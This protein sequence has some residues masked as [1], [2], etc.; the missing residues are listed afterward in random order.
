MNEEVEGR[1]NSMER[2][3]RDLSRRVRQMEGGEPP[4]MQPGPQP[5]A[6]VMHGP[7]RSRPAG[8]HETAAPRPAEPWTPSISKQD[9]EKLLGGRILAW[10]GGAA[11]L[12]GI[13]FMLG[14]AIDS[15]WFNESMR[16]LSAFLGSTALLI[17]GV[18][19]H[20]RK[21]QTE[22]ALA[23]VASALSGLY[24]TLLVSTQLYELVPTAAGLACAAL[25]G[26]VGVAIAVRWQSPLVGAIGILGALLAPVLVD[27]GPTTLSLAFMTVALA[28]AVGVLLWQKWDWLALGAFV[29]SVPQLLEWLEA[30]YENQIEVS[31]GVLAAY[32]GL[33]LLAAIGYQLRA[34]T[35]DE[36]PV[37]SWLILLAN[38]V[39]IAGGGYFGL[40]DTGH[41]H[42][43]IAWVLGLAGAHVALGAVALRL[44]L[45]REIGY[46]LVAE[47]LGLSALG[48]AD[49]LDGPFLVA[50]WALQAGLLAYA[51]TLAS[52]DE[53]PYGSAAERL[54][55]A[56]VG[57]LT[58]AIGHVLLVEA[59]PEA[60]FEGVRDLGD[61]VLGLG[62]CSAAALVLRYSVRD[63]DVRA[64]QFCE[65]L[66][67]TVFLYMASVAI[68]DVAGVTNDG[69][70]RQVGQAL[71]SALWTLGGLIAVVF[72]LLRDVRHVRLAGLS[73]LSIAITKVYTYDLAELEEMS[74]VL[75]LIALGI[76]LLAGAFAYQR[77][78]VGP[79]DE[80][81]AT[82]S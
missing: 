51:S 53:S 27:A 35:S 57:F 4:S 63:I 20:E 65:L 61:A 15:G 6:P 11:I 69:E 31:L 34:R 78:Q 5:Q 32:W 47:G 7:Q 59:P 9:F 52:R 18:W 72:G 42:A 22:A 77:I 74:R 13:A 81:E 16:A 48:F 21:G 76:F 54:L 50:G 37:A 71:L 82:V 66:A 30:H 28:S 55:F 39:L 79:D 80:S 38:T 8:M 46:L 68:I 17:A 33:Y 58:L 45:N 44:P 10:V 49:A 36:L 2:R 3:I 73:L 1:L 12:L 14:I 67:G 70:P 19:L 25:V 41:E 62:A 75:S 23:A 29:V 64:A 24:A 60:L 43:A 40:T 56:A 26:S